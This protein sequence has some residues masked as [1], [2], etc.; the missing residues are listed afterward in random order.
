MPIAV[1][2]EDPQF[3]KVSDNLVKQSGSGAGINSTGP[4]TSGYISEWLPSHLVL[5]LFSSE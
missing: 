4:S 3:R 2:L 5:A 1:T